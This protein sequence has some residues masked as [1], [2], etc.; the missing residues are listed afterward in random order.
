ME[1]KP[2]KSCYWSRISH[3]D[4]SSK[5]PDAIECIRFPPNKSQEDTVNSYYPPVTHQKS[6]GEYRERKEHELNNQIKELFAPKVKRFRENYFIMREVF[7]LEQNLKRNGE[8]ANGNIQHL[9]SIN[10]NDPADLTSIKFYE[11]K[12][13]A[14]E[15]LDTLKDK[16]TMKE[17]LED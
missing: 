13:Q 1:R 11:T 15:G 10:V 12:E 9:S 8:W 2:C 6:C 3:F 16:I 17:F 14:L 4:I 5:G 7:I